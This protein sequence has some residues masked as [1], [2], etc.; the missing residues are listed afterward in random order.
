MATVTSSRVH[1]QV[2]VYLHSPRARLK[3]VTSPVKDP[4]AQYYVDTP[5][6]FPHLVVVLILAPFFLL[7]LPFPYIPRVTTLLVIAVARSSFLSTHITRPIRPRCSN[8]PPSPRR[9]PNLMAPA[10]LCYCLCGPDACRRNLGRA[11]RASAAAPL[12]SLDPFLPSSSKRELAYASPTKHFPRVCRARVLSSS[13]LRQKNATRRRAH[14]LRSIPSS[15]A[16]LLFAT[17][18][19]SGRCR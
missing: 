16:C 12:K 3:E 2:P 8:P 11:H 1:K 17:A 10:A 19:P 14:V 18:L 6:A 4:A 7:S 5:P 13:S 15:S 9:D